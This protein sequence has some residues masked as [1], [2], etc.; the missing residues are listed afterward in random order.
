M[1]SSPRFV[2]PAPLLLG[3]VLL[4]G[5]YMPPPKDVE[6]VRSLDSVAVGYGMVAKRDLTTSVSS[7]SGEVARRNSPTTLADMIDGR[8]AGVEVRRL[9]S[10]G[11]SVRIRGAHTFKGNAEPL[12]VVDGVPQHT[13]V[14]GAIFLDIDPRDVKSI[15]VL[16]DGGSTAI[17][18]ARGANG[19]ILIT[20][21]HADDY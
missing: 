1:R 9:A 16:K 10:G 14:G 8:I 15:E 6:P 5:C 4:V 12:Y 19:V 20:T 17:Y 21:R 7:V 3:A 2:A 11:I 18:G 13:D